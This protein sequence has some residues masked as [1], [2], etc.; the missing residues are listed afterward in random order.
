MKH[1]LLLTGAT[2]IAAIL[3]TGAATADSRGSDAASGHHDRAECLRIMLTNDDGFAAPGL[4]AVRDALIAAGHEVTVVAP[5]TNQSGTSA[6]ATFGG[7]LGVTHPD[8]HT[9]VVDGSPADATE[10]G[11]SAVF[12]SKPPDLVISGSNAGQNVAAAAIHSGTV[13]AA[14][15]AIEDGVP[16]IAVSTEVADRLPY[17]ATARFVVRLVEILERQARGERLLPAGIGLNVNYPVTDDPRPRPALTRIGNGFL[18]LGYSGVLPEVGA[19]TTLG[20]TVDTTVPERTPMADDTALARDR[21]SI[22]VIEGDYDADPRHAR[23]IGAGLLRVA[24]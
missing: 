9:Y 4:V 16:A 8:T 7:S 19:T 23:T 22:S 1:A 18:E 15:T 3:A 10:V 20:V 14:V 17:D 13:G 6:R 21:V 2:L 24:R 12:A 5:R 11:L